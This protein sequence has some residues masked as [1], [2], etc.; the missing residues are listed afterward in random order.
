MA[1]TEPKK[2]DSEPKKTETKAGAKP[3]RLKLWQKI[4]IG[5]VIAIVILVIIINSATSGVTKVSNEYINDIQAS[6][7]SAAYALM[8]KEAQATTTK[9]DFE[10]LVTKIG[11]IL[12]T[13]EKMTSKEASG[14][15]G[16]AATGKVTYQIKGTDGV[17]YNLTVNLQKEDGQWRVVNFESKK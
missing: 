3:K 13:Q 11:P 9:S 10:Q 14:Q 15:T 1:D 16:Q 2:T 17:T 4:V 6:N 12:N 8:T 5:I 7:G